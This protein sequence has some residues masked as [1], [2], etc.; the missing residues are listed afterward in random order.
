VDADLDDRQ[1][2]PKSR[3][4]LLGPRFAPPAAVQDVSRVLAELARAVD[5]YLATPD[6]APATER[7]YAHDWDDF[8]AFCELHRLERTLAGE[9]T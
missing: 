6:H 1:V 9:I 5:E 3:R 4:H 8:V 2:I 7:A